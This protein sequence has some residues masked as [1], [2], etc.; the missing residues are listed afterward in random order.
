M[1]LPFTPWRLSE[2]SQLCPNSV[3]CLIGFVAFS[4]QFGLALSPEFGSIGEPYRDVAA[5]VAETT[6]V[7]W[8]CV[9]FFVPLAAVLAFFAFTLDRRGAKIFMLSGWA[10][11][12]LFFP[13]LICQ[14]CFILNHPT[15]G[16]NNDDRASWMTNSWVLFCGSSLLSWFAIVIGVGMCAAFG[17]NRVTPLSHWFQPKATG[18]Q[19]ILSDRSAGSQGEAR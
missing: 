16:I 11:M 10:T 7:A 18:S 1:L 9:G 14:F 17:P 13:W 8:P 5:C 4:V 19:Q 3:A 12:P 2:V 6:K 15:Y